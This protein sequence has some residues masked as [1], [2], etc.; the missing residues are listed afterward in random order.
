[1]EITN[2]IEQELRSKRLPGVDEFGEPGEFVWPAYDRLS[3]VN[4]PATA[5]A[6]LGCDVEGIAPPLPTALWPEPAGVKRVVMLVL[7]A[8][9]YRQLRQRMD[10]GRLPNAQRVMDMGLFVPLTSVFPSTTTAA[11]ASLHTGHA[12]AAHGLLAYVLYL[13]QFAMLV[14]MIRMRPL[15]GQGNLVDWGFDPET[16]IPLPGIAALLQDQGVWS[17]H[18]INS[19]FV[20]TPLSRIFYRDYST[21]RAI[22]SAADMFVQMRRFL[23]EHPSEKLFVS[24]YWGSVD[25]VAHF[26]GPD[27]PSWGAEVETLF[28]AL[29]LHL[30]RPLAP[31]A[32]EGT[33]LLLMSDHGQ[34]P[35]DYERG[36][37]VDEHPS[38]EQALL[39]PP[40]GESRSAF[41]YA[42]PGRL[43][44]VQS[45]LAAMSDRLATL[46]SE[47]AL[48]AGLFGTGPVAPETPLRIGD[49]LACARGRT[50]IEADRSY[51]RS[52]IVG[53]HGGLTPDEMLIPYLAV[54]LDE[55]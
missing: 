12:P 43:Q 10:S 40:A 20:N 1:M 41:L 39:L 49:L 44:A 24:G 8:I 22:H 23:D 32:R 18:F 45:D 11:L 51:E 2:Q 52:R 27:H 55:F 21:V 5:M 31:S 3:L 47:E 28:D 25:A 15:Y 48:A 34:V 6:L 9:G 4:V 19:A 14:E 29:E 7:D 38:M 35:I 16:F 13:K 50:V 30:L 53:R 36:V 46:P 54:R 42:R 17:V 33:V 26:R 37:F